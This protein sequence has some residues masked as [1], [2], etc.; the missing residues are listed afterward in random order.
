MY[1][2]WEGAVLLRAS[3]E[4][5]LLAWLAAIFA[6]SGLSGPA[7]AQTNQKSNNAA[8]APSA[9]P[10]VGSECPPQRKANKR[11]AVG[12]EATATERASVIEQFKRSSYGPLLTEQLSMSVADVVKSRLNVTSMSHDPSHGTQVS[13]S[14]ADGRIFLWYPGNTVIL[15]GRWTAC[16]DH[17]STRTKPAPAGEA[18]VMS[19]GKA[20][21]RYNTS[22]ANPITGTKGGE[23]ECG[24]AGTYLKYRVEQRSGDV[25]GLATMTAIPFVVAKEKTTI[26]AL[27]QRMRQQ[28]QPNMTPGD[29]KI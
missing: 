26:D 27:P 18:I 28:R 2:Q 14:A 19:Y 12:R 1:A 5:F 17:I 11:P 6:A 7:M 20:C 15:D 16:Q 8:A 4:W 29:R 13:Y 23:W 22:S 9:A 21:F 25:L 10:A 24:A 3:H